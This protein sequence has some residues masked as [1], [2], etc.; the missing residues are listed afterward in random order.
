MG[1]VHLM[2]RYRVWIFC[3][4]EYQVLGERRLEDGDPRGITNDRRNWYLPGYSLEQPLSDD[5]AQLHEMWR[6]R[7]IF[8][9]ETPEF[10]EFVHVQA[11]TKGPS[12]KSMDRILLH[13][14]AW[15]VDT[16]DEVPLVCAEGA[17]RKW[18]S[19]SEFMCDAPVGSQDRAVMAEFMEAM[20]L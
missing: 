11:S 8:W 16:M 19:L 6:E 20:R 9:N 3:N 17:E 1:V 10:D 14:R 2:A 7:T 12:H 5:A 13:A 18:L 15:Y 4:D